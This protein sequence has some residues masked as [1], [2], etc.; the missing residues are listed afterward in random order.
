MVV[1]RN[2]GPRV[3]F[4]MDT[5]VDHNGAIGGVKAS[6]AAANPMEAHLSSG[7]SPV[8]FATTNMRGVWSAWF[9]N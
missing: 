6:F 9:K 3:Y 4:D 7:A 5:G 8:I 1:L 2:L